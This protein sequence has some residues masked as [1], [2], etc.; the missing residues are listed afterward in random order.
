ME[1]KVK[2]S[3]SFTVERGGTGDG[4]VVRNRHRACTT[5]WG[6]GDVQALAANKGYVLL[7][8]VAHV[9]IKGHL[10]ISGLGWCLRPC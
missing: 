1:E 7:M 9:A 8:S 5:T 2:P 3:G 6:H 4:T 10:Y